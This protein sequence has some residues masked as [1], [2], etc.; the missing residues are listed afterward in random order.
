MEGK[1]GLSKEPECAPIQGRDMRP[2][3]AVRVREEHG[4]PPRRQG[5]DQPG[6]PT[7]IRKAPAVSHNQ[8]H[9]LQII[10]PSLGNR[11]CE[12]SSTKGCVSGTGR[13]GD[14]GLIANEK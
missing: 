3:G 2:L 14:V 5:T 9:Y 6:V 4:D 12:R 1:N 13:R 11:A 8:H 10:F 7:L